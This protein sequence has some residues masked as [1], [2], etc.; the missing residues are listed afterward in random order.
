MIYFLKFCVRDI[1]EQFFFIF[2]KKR[3]ASASFRDVKCCRSPLNLGFP[4]SNLIFCPWPPNYF[5]LKFL[6]PPPP[7]KLGAAATMALLI[8]TFKCLQVLT[9]AILGLESTIECILATQ[10]GQYPKVPFHPLPSPLEDRIAWAFKDSVSPQSC[11][12]LL[13]LEAFQ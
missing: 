2:N 3:F 10:N 6:V 13:E 12:N 4:L 11:K 9:I 7:R 5:G 1:K 8:R